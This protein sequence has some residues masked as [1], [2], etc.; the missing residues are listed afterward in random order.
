MEAINAPPMAVQPIGV[1]KM[2]QRAKTGMIVL[3]ILGLGATNILTLVSEDIHAAS[4]NVIRSILLAGVGDATMSRILSKS[5]TTN[6]T[7]YVANFTEVLQQRNL[8]LTESNKAIASKHATLEKAHNE[9]NIKHKELTRTSGLRAAATTSFTKRLA[10]RS[11]I[12]ASRNLSSV[13]AESIPYIGIGIVVAVTALD[14][15]DACET[16]KDINALNSEFGSAH[17][18]QAKVC[19]LNVPTRQQIL[20]QVKSNSKNTYE[21]TANLLSK[22]GA[23]VPTT[24]PKVSWPELKGSICPL[25]G[26]IAA[27]CP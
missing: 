23:M 20:A 8:S 22:G 26:N 17:E 6:R 24:I 19:G 12:N 5:P 25:V 27:V 7:K 1:T 9:V 16:L 4:Y 13:P 11:A 18:D 21:S 10:T 2:W 3:S 14:L 15:Y